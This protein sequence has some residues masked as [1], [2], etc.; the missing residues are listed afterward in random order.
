[1]LRTTLPRL[2]PFALTVVSVGWLLCIPVLAYIPASP[3]NNTNGDTNI[4]SPSQLQLRW[5]GGGYSEAVSYQLV[6]AESNGVSRGALVHFSE[7]NLSNDTT[8]TPWIALVSCD[9]NATD[10]SMEDDVFTLARDRGAVSALLYSVYSERCEINPFYAD[11]TQ[12]DQVMDIFSS[13]S[14]SA[15]QMIETEYR[16]LNQSKYSNFN[17]TLLNDTAAIV[18]TTLANGTYKAPNYLFATLV[19]SNATDDPGTGDGSTGSTSAPSDGS[20]QGGGSNPHSSLAMII[21]YAITGCVSALFCVVIISGA[22]R[23]IRHPE[24]YGPRAGNGEFGPG[25]TGYSPQSRARG[26]TRAILDTFPIVKFDRGAPAAEIPAK[27][28]EAGRERD[29]KDEAG[30]LDIELRSLPAVAVILQGDQSD[31]E[32]GK[33]TAGGVR[34]VQ[35]DAGLMQRAS[36]ESA[37]EGG[38]VQAQSKPHVQLLVP[39]PRPSRSAGR[40][41][42][43]TL[44]AMSTG[45]EGLVPD[46]I[47][48]E[49]CPI[50]IVDF[51]EGDDLR[52]LPCEGH[53]R[54]HQQCVDQWLL[55][56]SSSC[57]IC[58]QD[59]HVLETMMSND[60]HNNDTDHLEPPPPLGSSSRPL[61][62]AGARLSRYLRLARHTRR[63]NREGVPHGYDPTD[64]HMPMA[65]DTSF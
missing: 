18:N 14:L 34:E 54:F 27:D 8:T 52:V 65:P 46:A 11:P 43:S 40:Q 13:P 42:A 38:E 59:F 41:E 39:G 17:A 16:A 35:R 49:T 62:T 37:G 26:L 53:H 55:E 50:C 64:P 19:A 28:V 36:E 45:D 15:S 12:F 51:E 44:S 21:L 56:L 7:L 29:R 5:Y 32:E 4:T 2:W 1:M 6:G 10:A 57:P 9:A 60:G 58:R 33:D 30:N 31:G 63:R 48:R 23:A 22:I 25:G 20:T 47:G 3:T 61:S 24:R